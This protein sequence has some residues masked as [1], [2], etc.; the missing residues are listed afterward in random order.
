MGSSPHA[1]KRTR[2]VVHS[3]ALGAWRFLLLEPHPLLR[4]IVT[5]IWYGEG[6]VAYG[7]DRILPR[8]SSLLLVNVGPPQYMIVRGPTECR[9]PFTDIWYS[10]I[11]EVPIDTEAPLGSRVVGVA[12]TATGAASVLR[13]PSQLTANRTGSLEDLI[14]AEARSLHQRMLSL[15]SP[16]E[17]LSCIQDFLLRRCSSGMEIHPLVSW[18]SQWISESGGRIGTRHLVRESGYSRKHFAALFK[19]HIGIV[20]KALARVHRFQRALGAITAAGRRDWPELAVDVGYYDQ[21]HMINEF[22]NLT[23]LTPRELSSKSQPDANSVV[24]W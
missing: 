17:L 11:S 12:F 13:L 7:R 24:L 20:P 21:A 23:G 9:I 6:K 22:R 14:G 15:E 3:S 8:A 16:S 2:A 10:G 5:H 1:D 18:A 19:E 4:S